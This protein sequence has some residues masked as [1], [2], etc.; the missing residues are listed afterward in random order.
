MYL[1]KN[2]T[3]QIKENL[4]IVSGILRVKIFMAKESI[5]TY[6]SCGF[7]SWIITITKKKNGEFSERIS[8]HYLTS[9]LSTYSFVLSGLLANLH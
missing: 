3:K 1:N 5:H 9:V 8:S 6:F 2:K 7:P 4:K